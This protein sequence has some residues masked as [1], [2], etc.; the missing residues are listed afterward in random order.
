MSTSAVNNTCCAEYL[1]ISSI[2]RYYKNNHGREAWDIIT[3]QTTPTS[4]TDHFAQELRN[5]AYA[6]CFEGCGYWGWDC[7]GDDCV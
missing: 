6:Y 7:G 1:H 5:N 2:N 3:G 4:T